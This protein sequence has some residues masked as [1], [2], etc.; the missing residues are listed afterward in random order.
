MID[1]AGLAAAALLLVTLVALEVRHAG[2]NGAQP[3]HPTILGWTV[4][5]KAVVTVMWLLF[6]VLLFPRVLGLLT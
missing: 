2:P 3:V 4:N 1:I 5:M 6:L